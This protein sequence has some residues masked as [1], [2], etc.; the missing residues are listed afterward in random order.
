MAYYYE[1]D[2]SRPLPIKGLK[3]GE[4]IKKAWW[5]TFAEARKMRSKLFEDHADILDYFIG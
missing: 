5:F 4:G 1:L 2:S 3:G